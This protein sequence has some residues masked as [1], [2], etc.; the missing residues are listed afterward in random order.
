MD[1]GGKECKRPVPIADTN[2]ASNRLNSFSGI[3]TAEELWE[4]SSHT[5][6]QAHCCKFTLQSIE[7]YLEEILSL[8]TN[9]FV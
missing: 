7:H 2:A 9:I 3:V 6:T 5:C 1:C 8:Y 4:V